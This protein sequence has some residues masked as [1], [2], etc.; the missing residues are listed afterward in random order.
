VEPPSVEVFEPGTQENVRVIGSGFGAGTVV[1]TVVEL[2]GVALDAG[3]FT[4]VDG[5]TL[6]LDLPPAGV[7]AHALTVRRGARS[8]STSLQVR[9]PTAPRLQLGTGDPGNAIGGGQQLRIL[10]GGPIGSQQIVVMSTRLAPSSSPL[11]T[12]LI[13]AGSSDL[14][15]VA[16]LAIPAAGFASQLLL[17][18]P[19]APVLVYAQTLSL[20]AGSPFPASNLQ[21]VLLTP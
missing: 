6:T 5:S 14:H 10:A 17:P 20:G 1:G 7:G 3:S 11:G 19:S 18:H 2:D 13:G 9:T 15:F 12:L 4:I 8:A 16:V 21:S